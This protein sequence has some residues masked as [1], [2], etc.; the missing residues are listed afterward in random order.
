[1]KQCLKLILL[2]VPSILTS[3]SRAHDSE[4][5]RKQFLGKSTPEL[6]SKKEHWLGKSEPVT[7]AGLKGRMV[8]LQFNF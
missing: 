8:W 5:L 6:E 7:L 4:T 2:L 1:M 3:T